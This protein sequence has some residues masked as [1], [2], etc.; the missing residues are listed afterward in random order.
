MDQD[1]LDRMSS[2]PLFRL[3]RWT[4]PW[5]AL[6]AVL[7]VVMGLA[8]QYRVAAGSAGA[9]GR[10]ASSTV[11]ATSTADASSSVTPTATSGPGAA[12]VTPGT[13]GKLTKVGITLVGGIRLRAGPSID[14]ATLMDLPKGAELVILSEKPSWYQVREPG[15]RVGW[16]KVGQ[17]LIRVVTK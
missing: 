11:N 4:A 12:G 5:V 6:A 15:G 13:G 10:D 8:A 2:D 9:A 1:R 3:V 7:W 16:V 17:S 14:A